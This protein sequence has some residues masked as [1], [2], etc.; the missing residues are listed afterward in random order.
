[1]TEQ[2]G[3]M[4]HRR[5]VQD[6]L[7]E[8][9]RRDL[10]RPPWW[11]T[12]WGRLTI[13]GGVLVVAGAGVAGVVLLDQRPVSDTSVVQCLEGPYR[14]PDGSLSGA[15][16]SIATPDGVLPIEDAEAV[17]IQMWESGAFAETDPTS[18]TSAPGTAPSEFTMCVT[19][20]GEAA[21]VPGRI[22]CSTLRLHPFQ[23]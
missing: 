6:L 15:G 20:Q 13:A 5:E 8:Q 11:K 3:G 2:S 16:V 21:V 14:N 12:L 1:M 17:C 4:P 7:I 18:A 10:S 19:D 22:E 23:E 9:M